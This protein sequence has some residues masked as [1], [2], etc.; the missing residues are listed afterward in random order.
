MPNT[1]LPTRKCPECQGPLKTHEWKDEH[2]FTFLGD[3]TTRITIERSCPRCNWV[4][5]ATLTKGPHEMQPTQLTLV[6]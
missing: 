3:D 1:T 5:A 2:T 4:L 6:T